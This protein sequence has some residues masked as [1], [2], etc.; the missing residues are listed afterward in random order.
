MSYEWGQ[1]VGFERCRLPKT[2]F[3]R[4]TGAGGNGSFDSI[5]LRSIPLRMTVSKDGALVVRA[6]VGT[7]PYMVQC[8]QLR[9]F[10]HLPHQMEASTSEAVTEEVFN[11]RRH[12]NSQFSILNY[13]GGALCLGMKYSSL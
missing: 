10:G 11:R 9:I 5:P 7:G 13:T 12:L 3:S 2:L 1:W 6:G 8:H 4:P